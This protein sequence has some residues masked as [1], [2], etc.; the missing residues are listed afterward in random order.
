[1]NRRALLIAMAAA[2]AAALLAHAHHPGADLDRLMG[3]E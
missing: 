2:A 3:S 1:M